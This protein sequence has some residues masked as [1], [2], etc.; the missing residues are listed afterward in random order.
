M[1]I[2]ITI[3]I[4]NE[5]VIENTQLYILRTGKIATPR[6][7]ALAIDSFPSIGHA[8][9]NESAICDPNPAANRSP[10]FKFG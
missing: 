5:F 3:D 9:T 7:E 8:R 6:E 10:Y 1:Q 2:I 4:G